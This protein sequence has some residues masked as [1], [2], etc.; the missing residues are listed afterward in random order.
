MR[1]P[2]TLVNI[3][4][5]VETLVVEYD[6]ETHTAHE[7]WIPA[8]VCGVSRGSLSVILADGTKLDVWQWRRKQRD[9][10]P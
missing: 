4:D 1:R 9:A 7:E 5:E 3:G 2:R 6:D 10:H 8:L